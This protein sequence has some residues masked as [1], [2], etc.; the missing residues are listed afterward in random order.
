[1]KSPPRSI[2]EKLFS[3]KDLMNSFLQ[4]GL[5]LIASMA[6]FWF[7]RSRSL[8]FTFLSLSNIGLIFANM[9]G[10]S[11]HQ[12]KILFSK[13]SNILIVVF[14]TCCLILI[15]NISGIRSLFKF[16]FTNLYHF[17]IAIS[18]A[19]IYFMVI[20]FWNRAKSVTV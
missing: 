12:L 4:G 14:I 16:E 10:G 2:H 13:I 19:L 8:V 18:L 9:S 20:G 6:L 11:I 15:N 7:T 17:L 1:M 5:I 3:G